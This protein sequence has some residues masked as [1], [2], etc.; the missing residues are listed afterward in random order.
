MNTSQKVCALVYVGIIAVGAIRIKSIVNE[1]REERKQIE[2]NAVAE[3]DRIKHAASV[4]NDRMR[5]GYY[6]NNLSIER[7]LTDFEFEI[8]VADEE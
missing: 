2:A 5:R 1:G 6:D 8:I 4:V 7:V 3:I